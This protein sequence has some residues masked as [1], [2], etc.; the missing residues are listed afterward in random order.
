MQVLFRIPVGGGIPIYTFAVVFALVIM[1]GLVLGWLVAR[2]YGVSHDT[3][4][5]EVG[6]RELLGLIL[7]VG[8]Y[9]LWIRLG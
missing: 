7:G 4:L 2:R 6:D 1:G 9:W 5:S 8:V 3:Y